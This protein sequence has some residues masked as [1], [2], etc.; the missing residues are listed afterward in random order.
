[1]DVVKVRVIA[2]AKITSL[3]AVKNPVLENLEAKGLSR[4]STPAIP[5][6]GQAKTA[7]GRN[8]IGPSR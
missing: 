4:Y 8:S 2:A 3:L 7:E 6:G 1:V 5:L